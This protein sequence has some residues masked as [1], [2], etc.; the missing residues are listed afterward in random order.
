V[1]LLHV[2]LDIFRDTTVAT[3]IASL[4]SSRD[5][6]QT[7]HESSTGSASIESELAYRSVKEMAHALAI[8]ADRT[9]STIKFPPNET[10]VKP[11]SPSA[12]TSSS[13]SSSTSTSTRTSTSTTSEDSVRVLTL[14]LETLGAGLAWPTDRSG[15]EVRAFLDTE[16]QIIDVCRRILQMSADEKRRRVTRRKAASNATADPEEGRHP[17]ASANKANSAIGEEFARVYGDLVKAALCVVG[18]LSIR[19]PVVQEDIRISGVFALVLSHCT[20]DFAN[21]LER[22]WA[23]MCVRNACEG[24]PANQEFI[25]SLQPQGVIQDETLRERGI[26]VN[27]DASTGKFTV[28]QDKK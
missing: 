23:L 15:N 28:D 20:T 6:D 12:D 4:L 17:P 19:C 10:A 24:C 26:S 2:V 7:T 9:I 22:E 8:L 3:E 18:N 14:C 5:K 11:N 25:S 1:I 21:P 16:T 27:F 13:T